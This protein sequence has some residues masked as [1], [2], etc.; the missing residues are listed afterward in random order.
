MKENA[1]QMTKELVEE[2]ERACFENIES[3]FPFTKCIRQRR[4]DA[5]TQAQDGDADVVEAGTKLEGNTWV[6]T[7]TASMRAV[8]KSAV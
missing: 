3:A 1:K 4:V 6:F 8:T 5:K 2:V 7:S